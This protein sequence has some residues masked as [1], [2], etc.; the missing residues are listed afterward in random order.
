MQDGYDWL[1]GDIPVLRGGRGPCPVCGH[2][3]GDCTG[4]EPTKPLTRMFGLGIFESLDSKQ[5][6]TVEE[7]VFVDEEV[8]PDHFIRVRKYRIGQQIPLTEAREQGLTNL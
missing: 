7:D 8:A 1:Y 2:P 5:M 4:S 3:T 6:F